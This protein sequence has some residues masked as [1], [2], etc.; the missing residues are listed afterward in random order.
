MTHTD[1]KTTILLLE[2]SATLIERH[3]KKPHEI[4]KARLCRNMARKLKKEMNKN[5]TIK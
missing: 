4:D 1:L 2:R 3:C 5:I